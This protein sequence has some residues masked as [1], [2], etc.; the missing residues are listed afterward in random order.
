MQKNLPVEPKYKDQK[1][2]E[3]KSPLNVVFEVFTAGDNKSGVQ[4]LAFVLPN[5]EKVREEKGTKKVFLKNMM[6]AKFD[7]VLIPISKKVLTPEDAEKVTFYAYFN[8][9]ILH[10]IS[11]ILGVN[12][13]TLDDGSKITVNKA[14]EEHYSPIEESKAD[15]LGLYNVP[16]LIEK[17]W[18]PTQKEQE[19]YTTYLAGMFRSMR[20]GVHEAHGLGTLIQFNFLKEK[21]AFVY[22]EESGKFHV[23]TDKLKDAI[24]EL[25]Q[26][27][28]IL[29][30]DGN[31][32]NVEKFISRYGKLDE[33][34]E[35]TIASLSDIPVDIEPLFKY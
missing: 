6:E 10:E 8:E 5:D 34:T 14:L 3:L 9:V 18:I 15:V 21:G 16:F 12:Y 25:A 28:L 32:E 26:I 20:F 30:G 4:T 22:D 35:R 17:G 2:A 19:I 31:Y 24:K 27:L 13:V 33:L 7:K 29:E 11:H 1:I 23:D